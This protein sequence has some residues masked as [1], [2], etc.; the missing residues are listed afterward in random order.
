MKTR[1]LILILIFWTGS[2]LQAQEKRGNSIPMIGTP[3]PEFTAE[4]TNGLLH[5]PEDLG[6]QYWKILFSHPQDFTPVCTSEIM[7]LTRMQDELESHAIKIAIISADTKERHL[8]WKKSIEEAVG[9]GNNVEPVT[10]KF[11][12]IEDDKLIVSRLYGMV[13]DAVSST[14]D[15]RGVYIISPDNKIAAIFFY[16]TTIGRNMDEIIRTVDALQTA[17]ASKL[18]TPVNWQPGSDLIVPHYPYTTE[19]LSKNPSIMDKYWSAGS[20]LWYK[21]RLLP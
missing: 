9:N 4:T 11:P 6:G 3:A 5:F 17:T 14:K 12:L 1:I 18:C 13:H 15:I 8:L 16:P 19:E 10:I 7:Q 21:K 20:F 2:F